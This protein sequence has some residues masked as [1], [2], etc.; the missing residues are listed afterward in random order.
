MSQFFAISTP[1]SIKGARGIKAPA[2]AHQRAMI[3]GAIAPPITHAITS[4]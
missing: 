2:T 4:P 1:A 3:A